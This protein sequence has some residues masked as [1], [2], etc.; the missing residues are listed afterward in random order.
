M[1]STYNINFKLYY[2]LSGK[3]TTS[4]STSLMTNV[5]IREEYIKQTLKF[6]KKI[7]YNG[8]EIGY[9]KS[10][11]DNETV[12]CDLYG[13]TMPDSDIIFNNDNYRLVT[14]H[15]SN[16]SE[17]DDFDKIDIRNIVLQLVH[18]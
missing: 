1:I 6:K 3:C 9:A 10:I 7:Y 2:D 8:K 17:F 16:S 13:Q 14:S 18:I 12:N 4:D 15:S 5:K 11:V